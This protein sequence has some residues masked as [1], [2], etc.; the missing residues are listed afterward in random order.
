MNTNITTRA[1]LAAG[2]AV[3]ATAAAVAGAGVASAEPDSTT[4]TDGTRFVMTVSDSTPAVGQT[5]SISTS[6]ER[7]GID[8]YIYNYKAL[9]DG[10]LTYVEGTTNWDNKPADQNKV[11]SSPADAGSQAFVRVDSPGPTPKLTW[12]V[13]AGVGHL[14]SPKV[15]SM[16]FIVTKGCATGSPMST[17]MHYGGSLG[18]GI[19]TDKGPEITV[20]KSSTPGGG[21][22]GGAGTGTG[23]NS[24]SLDT[25]SLSGLFG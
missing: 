25:G 5:I 11:Q 21:T 4:W 24:G 16:D 2:L 1:R 22:G 8:E 14:G 19:Y 20:A 7:Q 18:D 9:F 12:K 3:A 23:G 13:T 10:C 17:T 6:F 15:I